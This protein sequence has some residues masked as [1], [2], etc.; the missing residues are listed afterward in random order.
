[1]VLFQASHKASKEIKPLKG[2]IALVTG[3]ARGV[4]R[5]IALQLAE[6]GATTYVSGRKPNLSS[7]VP[8][9]SDTIN[10]QALSCSLSIKLQFFFN[11]LIIDPYAKECV[12]RISDFFSFSN[13]HFIM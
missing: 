10:G 6:A 4:G 3:G 5:G 1:M 2:Q 13:E 12:E 9:L 11:N 7:G 8:T